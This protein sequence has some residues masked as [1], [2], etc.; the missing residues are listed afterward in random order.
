MVQAADLAQSRRMIPDYPT[1]AQCFA[2]YVAVV[3]SQD[4]GRIADMMAYQATVAKCA[5]KYKWPL[6]LVYDANFRQEAAGKDIP[7]A[8]VD[9]SIYAQCF[10]G[11]AITNENWCGRCQSLDHGSS[12]CPLAPHKRPTWGQAAPQAKRATATGRETCRNFNRQDS[13]CK[14]GKS[15][16]YE[17][18]CSTS[19]QDHPA[20]RCGDSKAEAGSKLN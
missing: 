12:S 19:K 20:S 17:H 2:L 15:C 5:L 9:P 8:R 11:Q 4:K 16:K 14:F 1:W 18:A 13:R 7:W 6:W 3:T 10:T